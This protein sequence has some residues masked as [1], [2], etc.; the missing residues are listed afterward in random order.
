MNQ[1]V[2]QA[3]SEVVYLIPCKEKHIGSQII[4][5]GKSQVDLIKIY[6][7]NV[8]SPTVPVVA[9]G[10][11][12]TA[13]KLNGR[14]HTSL[15]ENRWN[16]HLKKN[17]FG[18]VLNAKSQTLHPTFATPVSTDSLSRSNT[19]DAG[20]QVNVADAKLC[21]SSSVV[22]S[23]SVVAN[24][25]L[26][27]NALNVD[28]F[29]N[30]LRDISEQGI[31]SEGRDHF[32]LGDKEMSCKVP[33]P[34]SQIH[35]DNLE[36][37]LTH[38]RHITSLHDGDICSAV[39]DNKVNNQSFV[40]LS[41]ETLCTNNSYLDK[42]LGQD[43]SCS[44]ISCGQQ[45]VKHQL[46]SNELVW[47]Q[48]SPRPSVMPIT[49][50][51]V[52]WNCDQ[53]SIVDELLGSFQDIH[54]TSSDEQ[55]TSCNYPQQKIAVYD[56]SA[57]LEVIGVNRI[58]EGVQEN[59]SHTADMIFDIPNLQNVFPESN[60]SEVTE[61]SDKGNILQ[62]TLNCSRFDDLKFPESSKQP[63]KSS[64]VSNIND[65]ISDVA[66]ILDEI[67]TNEVQLPVPEGD[68]LLDSA[69]SD[70]PVLDQI[71]SCSSSISGKAQVDDFI[72]SLDGTTDFSLDTLF[73]TPEGNQKAN[74]NNNSKS[75]R[76]DLSNDAENNIYFDDSMEKSESALIFS[77]LITSREEYENS[78]DKCAIMSDKSCV[79]RSDHVIPKVTESS[80]SV[81]TKIIQ[82]NSSCVDTPGIPKRVAFKVRPAG[83]P[84]RNFDKGRTTE[85]VSRIPKLMRPTLGKDRSTKLDLRPHKSAEAYAEQLKGNSSSNKNMFSPRYVSCK[86]F[87]TYDEP[88]VER[89]PSVININEQKQ[90]NLIL[91]I[92][93][94]GMSIAIPNT[95]KTDMVSFIPA[96][97]KMCEPSTKLIPANTSCSQLH[98]SS[99]FIS[100]LSKKPA[101]QYIKSNFQNTNYIVGSSSNT[102]SI[103]TLNQVIQQTIL[104]TSDVLLPVSSSAVTFS[105]AGQ[106]IDPYSQNSNCKPIYVVLP[107]TTNT[108]NNGF[109]HYS[110]PITSI[111]TQAGKSKT[112]SISTLQIVQ[113]DGRDSILK[114]SLIK[115]AWPVAPAD[116]HVNAN[117]CKK[118]LENQ[119]CDKISEPIRITVR[120][121][122]KIL[123]H[124]QGGYGSYT[125]CSLGSEDRIKMKCTPSSIPKAVKNRNLVKELKIHF[126]TVPEAILQ[127]L[128]IP[129][130]AVNR[131]YLTRHDLQNLHNQ[132]LKLHL[133][134]VYRNHVTK[135]TDYN[136][137]TCRNFVG[138]QDSLKWSLK[139]QQN[140]SKNGCRNNKG[141]KGQVKPRK[142]VK[143]CIRSRNVNGEDDDPTYEPPISYFKAWKRK[144]DSNWCSRQPMK[145]LKVEG[146]TAAETTH[147]TNENSMLL[148]N[149]QQK[150]NASEQW[151]TA[152]RRS[153]SEPA[154]TK[155][156]G[157]NTDETIKHSQDDM[158]IKVCK[159]PSNIQFTVSLPTVDTSG[160]GFYMENLC[161]NSSGNVYPVPVISSENNNIY[162]PNSLE[163]KKDF[164]M[165]CKLQQWPSFFSDQNYNYSCGMNQNLNGTNSPSSVISYPY[166]TKS[167]E[168]QM[169][170]QPVPLNSECQYSPALYLE[171]GC[172]CSESCRTMKCPCARAGVLCRVGQACLCKNCDNPLNILHQYELDVLLARVDECLMQ[173]LYSYEISGLCNLLVSN[174]I[175]PCCTT[176]S[177]L[178]H[179]IPGTV[180]CNCCGNAVTYSWCTHS[181]HLQTV[182]PRNHCMVCCACKP[183]LHT[184]C[185]NCQQCTP[186]T[187]QGSCLECGMIKLFAV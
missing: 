144:I 167:T 6:L 170:P 9:S 5:A 146:H 133:S 172:N 149:E 99:D 92:G 4:Y 13:K 41:I 91:P 15:V 104:E 106:V 34:T 46:L 84:V 158:D 10:N 159:N 65:I 141:K 184:H 83:K 78:A 82:P 81:Q 135:C 87:A 143:K 152:L 79:N 45:C 112:N 21:D 75:T 181:V 59:K 2:N 138:Q 66:D 85:K 7:S 150:G 180:I 71:S 182:C 148:T 103:G 25:N 164:D 147:N 23:S 40:P 98:A 89:T 96:G 174:I 20:Y 140:K 57:S 94:T 129:P 63:S 50:S 1:N 24:E 47:T 186:S 77:E 119:T 110:L 101:I 176:T 127:Q 56:Q 123:A 17:N 8:R 54:C 177:K 121:R 55:T 48:Q 14:A 72:T 31:S 27:N 130:Q 74:E 162:Q 165:D 178:Q 126:P 76:N 113:I 42:S 154:I 68:F 73:Q 80:S 11:S 30:L 107:S 19:Y 69:Q 38:D 169:T 125:K 35:E 117:G 29:C 44:S 95:V 115:P 157:Q 28:E 183:T 67:H 49:S 171:K 137:E 18:C 22:Q 131:G 175:M 179:I 132:A 155:I 64:E 52:M 33:L 114:Q 142:S 168:S 124:N 39:T 160:S 153:L 70:S 116:S 163:E 32:P 134:I 166:A 93:T 156:V 16:N 109:A 88:I 105:T 173:N 111:T 97:E 53:E 128:T 108:L 187:S 37:S 161:E 36:T 122:P 86:Y 136:C 12:N 58:T 151:K 61:T 26:Q 118:P 139:E 51:N 43:T 3:D 60:S 102:K 145:I 100:G 90:D 62:N 185:Q 120:T